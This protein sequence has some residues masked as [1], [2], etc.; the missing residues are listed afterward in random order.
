MAELLKALHSSFNSKEMRFDFACLYFP[1]L[2]R[3]DSPYHMQVHLLIYSVCA[4]NISCLW[5]NCFPPQQGNFRVG[6][7]YVAARHESY[8]HCW[9][10]SG[11]PLRVTEMR[12]DIARCPHNGY[13]M[14]N[15]SVVNTETCEV[16]LHNIRT[17]KIGACR[18][19]YP[20]P[21]APLA[22]LLK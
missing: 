3:S 8:N 11:D 19:L 1:L 2:L 22:R 16:I 6:I 10:I 5:G 12:R 9:G 7:F 14:S 15:A 21:L 4:S 20:G 13:K 18:E 17:D